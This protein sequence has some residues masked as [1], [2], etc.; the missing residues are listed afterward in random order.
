M[1]K[2]LP[3]GLL[4]SSA[5]I[6][7][8]FIHNLITGID[9]IS[10][11]AFISTGVSKSIAPHYKATHQKQAA[12]VRSFPSGVNNCYRVNIIKG[13]KYLIRTMEFV[14]ASLSTNKELVYVP[15]FDY[16]HVCL[17][18]KGSGTPF[19]SALESRPLKT[20]TYLSPT[21]P[22]ALFLRSDVVMSTASASTS[23]NDNASMDFGWEAPDTTTGYNVYL[24][25]AELQICHDQKH[26][27]VDAMTN[28]KST[29][30]VLETDWEGD[31]CTPQEYVW[32]GI[33]LRVD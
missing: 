6:L 2:N 25:F 8:W 11:A 26:M 27:I 12:Y 24:H 14:D 20:I 31:P 30:G 1:F 21:A 10:D 3:F 23:T 29:Y 19:I 16:I 18:N 9:Y 17:V 7:I 13:T 32:E 4:G 15:T 28:I 22:Q 5:L 33:F